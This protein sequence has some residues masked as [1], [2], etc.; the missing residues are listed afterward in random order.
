MD[1]KLRYYDKETI[2]RKPTY[3]LY[4]KYDNK[5]TCYLLYTVTH[6][7]I[8]QTLNPIYPYSGNFN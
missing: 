8:P 1:L 7:M 2:T 3:L 5:E 4:S 6:I